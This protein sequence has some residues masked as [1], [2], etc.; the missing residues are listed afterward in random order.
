M[1]KTIPILGMLIIFCLLPSIIYSNA[2]IRTMVKSIENEIIDESTIEPEP[3]DYDENELNT[4][5]FSRNRGEGRNLIGPYQGLT[6][7]SQ[8]DSRWANKLYTSTNNNNQTMKSSGCG[9]TAAA[10]VV[11]SSIGNI[12]PSTMADLFVKEGFRTVANGTS[13]SAFPFISNYFA[14]D[15]YEYTSNFEKALNNLRNGNIIIVSCGNGLFTTN[16]HYI[17]LVGINNNTISIFDTYMYNGKF[18]IPSRKGKVTI[19]GNTIYCTIENFIK[20]SN[21][22][23]F[24]CYSNNEKNS[25]HNNLIYNTGNYKVTANVLMVRSGPRNKL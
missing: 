9:P 17:V 6:Y 5:N 24:W 2:S 4:L 25:I 21:Y 8:A 19:K 7:Y 11:S 20:Y 15:N 13:W 3:F 16:G 1:K 22:R 23:A 10:I 12:L 18:D 14:F